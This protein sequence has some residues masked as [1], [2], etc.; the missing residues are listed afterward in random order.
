MDSYNLA[1]IQMPVTESKKENL[2]KAEQM[3]RIAVDSGAD[4]AALPEMFLCPYDSG[5]FPSFAEGSGGPAVERLS[6]IAG[7]LGIYLIGG[8]IPEKDSDGRIYNSSFCFDSDGKMIGVHRKIHLFDIDIE[9]GISFR[10]SET[11]SPGSRATVLDTP[12]GKIGVAICFD[13]RFAELFR[14]MALEGAHTVIVPA[15]FNMTTGPVHWELSFR[16][17]AVDNQ[18]YMAGAAPARDPAAGYVSWAHSIIADPWGRVLEQLDED[19]GIIIREIEPDYADSIRQ[20]LP[21]LSG[22]RK[23]GYTL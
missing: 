9:G 11:L 14:F 23:D 7:D 5:R 4:V 13:I 18:I 3:L 20:Q 22:I 15:A 1:L 10:E 2:E 16:M 17:R 6:R 19:E 21:I 8:T 12:W